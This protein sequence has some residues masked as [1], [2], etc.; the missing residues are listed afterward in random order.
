MGLPHLGNGAR[1]DARSADTSAEWG[2]L[3]LWEWRCLQGGAGFQWTKRDPTLD[4]DPF[5]SES[6]STPGR[7]WD[8]LSPPVGGPQLYR[9]LALPRR[10]IRGFPANLE[11]PGRKRPRYYR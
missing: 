4:Q 5:R 1:L 2:D 11:Q 3:V 8:R 10:S 7:S 6:A 9:R